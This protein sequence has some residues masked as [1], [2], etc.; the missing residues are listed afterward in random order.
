MNAAVSFT[1]CAFG[2]LA[3]RML[4]VYVFAQLLGSFLAA[5]TVYAVYYGEDTLH[6]S[7]TL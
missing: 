5:G 6:A 1:M 4:P 7:N 2:R 3:W